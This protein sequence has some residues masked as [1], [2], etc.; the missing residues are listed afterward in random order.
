MKRTTILIICFLIISFL[1]FTNCSKKQERELPEQEKTEEPAATE[2]PGITPQKEIVSVESGEEIQPEV[3]LKEE[4]EIQPEIT[5]KGKKVFELQLVA[6]RDYARIEAEQNK[7]ARYG[8]NTFITTTVKGGDTYYRL[9]LDDL[10]TYSEA[11][12]LGEKLKK[13]FS[14]INE[15]WIQKVK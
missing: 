1:L 7:L 13:Q 4:E 2:E 10:Y 12:A 15:Y 11:F 8:Y 14:S 5:L 3:T 9:R 6:V